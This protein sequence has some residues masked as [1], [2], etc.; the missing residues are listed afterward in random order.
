MIKDT[1]F[2]QVLVAHV[3]NP[4]SIQEAEAGGLRI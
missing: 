3:C 2:N 4:S 1:H